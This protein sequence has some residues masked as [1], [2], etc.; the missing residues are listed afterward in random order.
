VRHRV[1]RSVIALVPMLFIASLAVVGVRAYAD[2][3]VNGTGTTLADYDPTSKAWNGM[4]TFVRLASGLGLEVIP[5][6]ALEWGD[7]DDSDILVLVYPLQRVEPNRLSAFIQAG[8][9]V[10]V[11]DDFGDSAAALSRLGLLRAEV[12]AGHASN[13]YRSRLYA[14]IAVPLAPGHPLVRG[15][16]EVI[17]NHPAIL[18]EVHG[19]TPVIGFGGDGGAVVVAGELGTGRFI[20]VSDPS[21]VIN[22]MLQF[23]GN[24]NLAVNLLRWLDRGGRAR[25]VI[26]LRGDVPM[27]GEPKAFIDDANLSRFGRS[28]TNVNRWLAG[29]NE[30][31]LTPIAMRI[32]GAIVAILLAVLALAAMPP[33]RRQ[34]VD[35][36]WLGPNRPERRDLIAR[37]VTDHDHGLANFLI[38]ATV[39]RDSVAAALSRA[40]QHPDP[41]TQLPEREVSARIRDRFGKDAGDRV[42]RLIPR[43]RA[44]PSRSHAAAEWIRGRVNQ[45]DLTALYADARALYGHLGEPGLVIDRPM[46]P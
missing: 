13:Y 24:L 22:R 21:I 7:L 31:L 18:S 28:L 23:P 40:L 45:R 39:L 38:P 19:A 12:G 27:Y 42:A 26:L 4:T 36:K 43:L 20:V 46:E 25:R 8:G 15:V 30:W 6:S 5:V 1:R 41:M 32:I 14:P 37:V 34:V 11:A 35:G 29:R 2:D 10:I 17:T 16:T 33:W 3:V 9:H 44:L